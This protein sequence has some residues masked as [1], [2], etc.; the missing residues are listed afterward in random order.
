[1]E[2]KLPENLYNIGTGKDLT[3]KELAETIQQLVELPV[4]SLSNYGTLLNPMAHL[5]N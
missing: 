2:N 5:E 1:L 4:V 3:I